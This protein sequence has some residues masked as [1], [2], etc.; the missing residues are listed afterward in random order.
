MSNKILVVY[1]VA[2]IQNSVDIV[3]FILQTESQILTE[4]CSSVLRHSMITKYYEADLEFIFQPLLNS[5]FANQ[6]GEYNLD[7][8]QQAIILAYKKDSDL[9]TKFAEYASQEGA[10]F[11]TCLCICLGDQP[12]S[13][14]MLN[15]CLDFGYEWVGNGNVDQT[16]DDDDELALNRNIS[17]AARVVEALECTMWTNMNT[18]STTKVKNDPVII[19]EEMGEEGL[20]V[21]EFD[22]LLGAM[23][24][25]RKQGDK[26]SHEQRKVEAEKLASKLFMMLGEDNESDEDQ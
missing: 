2:D 15:W 1:S 13:E 22:D 9:I 14:K 12:S 17:G 25:L 4:G 10:S 20:S 6:L 3:P 5:S 8:S 11:D 7:L 24:N 19:P 18:K 23:L 16:E 26:I 21:D